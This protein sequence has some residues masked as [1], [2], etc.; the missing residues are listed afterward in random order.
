MSKIIVAKD[1]TVYRVHE[2]EILNEAEI[3]DLRN[4]LQTELADLNTTVADASVTPVDNIS[5]Q[6]TVNQPV[7]GGIAAVQTDAQPQPV[8]ADEAPT[9]P[10]VLQ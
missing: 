10:V 2:F 4:R 5:A 1:G 9:A 6:E 3:S 8:L 7:D